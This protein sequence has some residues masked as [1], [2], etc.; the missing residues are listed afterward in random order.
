MSE[1]RQQYAENE[2]TL[3]WAT[4][5]PFAS[6][7]LVEET[8]REFNFVVNHCTFS[9]VWGRAQSS[10][11]VAID[12]DS[13]PGNGLGLIK[14]LRERLPTLILLGVSADTSVSMIRAVIEAGASDFLSLP[15]NAQELHKALIKA[16][17]PSTAPAVTASG[18]VGEV[19]TIYGVR[20]G[21]GATTVAV[22]LA[23]RM[24][25]L[26]GLD[27]ALVDLDLQRGDVAAFL[28]LTP[29]QSL[30]SLTNAPGEI[31][32]LFL[33]TTLTRHPSGVLV[34]P[35]PLQIEEA[36]S[37]THHDAERAL[38][39]LAARF[40]YTVVDTARSFTDVTL[41]AFELS[42]RILLVTD[43]SVPS[44]R[45]VRRTMD[46][47][48]RLEIYS[49]RVDVLVTEAVPGPVSLEDAVRSMGRQ[50]FLVIPRDTTAAC[51]AMNNGAPLN[52][53]R[54][55]NLS[56]TMAELAV[57]LSGAGES[58]PARGFLKR[59]FQSR[60]ELKA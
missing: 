39:L 54:P 7:A 12:L 35:A 8:A 23:V 22:N 24:A 33:R 37:V 43:L 19:I 50:P 21:L 59:I 27:V 11:V 40:R 17:H 45:A 20:G 29:A 47:L 25:T 26:T 57:K 46:L 9:A 18:L 36:E 1:V 48:D 32:D 3:L 53:T 41:A 56:R 31:D 5:G 16:A 10:E 34:L 51:K 42:S 52:G 28:N 60:K 14:I 2:R 6:R 13:N 15:L 4:D 49:E 44:L 38:R 58:Q 55:S 30:V